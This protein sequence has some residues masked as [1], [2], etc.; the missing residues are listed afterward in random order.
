EMIRPCSP[1]RQ[2]VS[3]DP[4]ARLESGIFSKSEHSV[5]P[6][7]TEVGREHFPILQMCEHLASF[8]PGKDSVTTH[9]AS[10]TGSALVARQ[11]R[12]RDVEF[13]KLTSAFHLL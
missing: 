7:S 1:P 9:S 8:S 11:R 4:R 2:C 13:K 6:T 12:K 5:A 3:D 10:R